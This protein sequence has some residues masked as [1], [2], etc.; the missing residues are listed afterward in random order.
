MTIV[1]STTNITETIIDIYS[2]NITVKWEIFYINKC[3]NKI[4]ISLSPFI[5]IF[6]VNY[7][8]VADMSCLKEK[9]LTFDQTICPVTTFQPIVLTTEEI[10]TTKSTTKSPR[11]QYECEDTN[12]IGS[13]CNVTNDI[14]KMSQPCRNQGICYFNETLP[15]QYMCK[16][17]IGYS[18]YDCEYDN[19]ICKNNTCWHDGNCVE[20]NGTVSLNNKTTFKCICKPGYNGPQ[21][22]LISD[23]CINIKCENKGV[24]I[25]SH[26]SW[27]CHCLDSS[28]YSGKYCEKISTSLII[29]QILSKSFASVAIVAIIAVFLFVIIMDILKY[30]F[31]IDP[32][33][34]ERRLMKLKQ[35]KKYLNKNRKKPRKKVALKVFYIS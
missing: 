11:G 2:D 3:E 5:C 1:F 10:Q 23:M 35:K 13:Y 21:C 28:L 8:E 25:S 16:C 12:Y 4:T 6:S 34:R 26:L 29:K 27:R 22:E 24:C 15:L 14:C 19:R 9:K 17:P 20:M 31:K 30:V 32:V 7:L 18:G 33:D